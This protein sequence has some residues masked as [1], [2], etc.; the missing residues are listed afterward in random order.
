MIAYNNEWLNNLL[1][2]NE[3]VEANDKH[4]ISKEELEQVYNAYPV[5]F[6][7]PNIFVRIG[8]FILTCIIVIFSL[9]LLS[10]VFLSAM[11]SEKGLGVSI[12]FFGFLI[13]AALEFMVNKNHFRSG[14][15][16][17]LMWVA[18][19]N[20]VSGFNIIADMGG[21]TNSL[22]IFAI[23][24]VLFLRYTNAV[25]ACIASLAFLAVI[26]FIVIRFGEIAKA[27]TPFVIMI[28]AALVYFFVRQQLKSGE[29]KLYETGLLLISVAMLVCFY[30]A[31]NYFIVREASI[32]M[33]DLQLKE[34][35]SIP[36]AWLFWIFTIFIPII[37]IA[38][39]IQKKDAVLL[40]VGLLLIAAVVFTIRYYYHLIPAELAMVLGGIVFIVLAYALIKYLH[41]PKYGFTY[42]EQ[43]DK[44]FMD[45]LHIESIVIAE[46]FTGPA[47]PADSGTQFGGGTGL[48]GGATGEF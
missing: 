35:E 10:L 20:I 39:G 44:F 6:Y 43:N 2:R 47:K 22:L 45:K 31:G 17:A 33:F 40:R 8:L 15:D 4:C 19:I 46:T 18:A 41:E 34:G 21:F 12:I 27:I 1:V 30:A 32:A 11:D 29:R 9:G 26:F 25:M 42:K 3:A 13:Y 14:V 24:F 28:V 48:G 16:D 7:T 36:F 38:R 5:K 37:Y 23:A